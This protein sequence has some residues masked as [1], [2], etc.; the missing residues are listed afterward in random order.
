MLTHLTTWLWQWT[1]IAVE[2][3]DEENSVSP[4]R[5]NH[6]AWCW[7][8]W[9]HDK[10]SQSLWHLQPIIDRK[11]SCPAARDIWTCLRDL[12][13]S[14]SDFTRLTKIPWHLTVASQLWRRKQ[15]LCC[16]IEK[17]PTL[18]TFKARR[19]RCSWQ[20]AKPCSNLQPSTTDHAPNV[21]I[22]K[23]WHAF[24]ERKTKKFTRI[25]MYVSEV[26]SHHDQPGICAW[27]Q[28]TWALFIATDFT[29]LMELELSEDHFGWSN[30]R[31]CWLFDRH[32]RITS[33]PHFT[34]T[35]RHDHEQRE[36]SWSAYCK[37]AVHLSTEPHAR[38]FNW[39]K[40]A[41][42]AFEPLLAWYYYWTTVIAIETGFQHCH[43]L[44][45]RE[46][47]NLELS[48]LSDHPCRA[49]EH[50]TWSPCIE[51]I[52]H[53]QLRRTTFWTRIDSSTLQR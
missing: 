45:T 33:L 20:F 32:H 24:N 4:V 9:I 35:P 26:G 10:L 36:F 34:T 41:E 14:L 12:L 40:F 22:G 25:E 30:L 31:P 50:C 6:R 11:Q 46:N 2:P 13:P 21:M 1:L 52:S 18:G 3:K 44:R 47:R 8:W 43:F 48:S 27:V 37:A 5:E 17:I 39:F 38:C 16:R 51:V 42:M 23:R 19:T 29:F 49:C 28:S 53:Q 15:G 7:I